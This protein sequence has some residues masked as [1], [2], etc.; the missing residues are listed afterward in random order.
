MAGRKTGYQ[1]GRNMQLGLFKG[2]VSRDFCSFINTA[3]LQDL[4]KISAGVLK[5]FL[6]QKQRKHLTKTPV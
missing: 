1:K 5:H 3:N 6:E 2:T 4:K